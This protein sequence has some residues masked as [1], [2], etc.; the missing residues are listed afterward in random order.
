MKPWFPEAIASS[1]FS[2]AFSFFITLDITIFSPIVTTNLV[3]LISSLIGKEIDSSMAL[4]KGFVK[5]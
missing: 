2:S 4:S 1:Y 3:R 5:N